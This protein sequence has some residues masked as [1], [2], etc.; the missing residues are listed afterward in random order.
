MPSGSGPNGARLAP[1]PDRPSP[2]EARN[3]AIAAFTTSRDSFEDLDP[4]KG[5]GPAQSKSLGGTDSG[6]SS[7]LLS[8]GGD[9]KVTRPFLQNPW[10]YA[11]VTAN[12][13]ALAS[14]PVV[15]T[16]GK[17]KTPIDNEDHPLVALFDAPNPL[18]SQAKF[19]KQ[20]VN[21]H[22]LWG[23]TYLILMKEDK[24]PA[25]DGKPARTEYRPVRALEGEGM[26]AKVETPD[27]VWPVAGHLVQEVVDKEHGPLPWKY[28]V[29]TGTGTVEYLAEA[30]VQLADANP[31]SLLRG[32]G[33]MTAVIRDAAKAY[34][35]DR[36][37][38]ALLA[39]GGVPGGV[40][41]V[42]GSLPDPELRAIRKAWRET[43]EKPD[44]HHK[45]AILPNG[46]K[47]TPHGFS[48]SEM[49]FTAFREW[50][51][52][53][54]MA[55]FG[56]TKPILG[57]TDDVN[58]SNAQEAY[59][60][61]WEVQIIPMVRFFE[62]EFNYKFIRRIK[63]FAGKKLR[64][65]LSLDD[66]EALR[67]DLDAKVDRTLKLYKDGHRTFNEAAGLAGWDLGE[68]PVTGG[69][70]RWI[71]SQLLPVELALEGPPEPPPA[72]DPGDDPEEDD[73]QED[74]DTT[75]DEPDED[76][77]KSI[78]AATEARDGLL[79]QYWRAHDEYLRGHE[80][81]FQKAVFGEFR[82][83]LRHTS[84]RLD[85]LARGAGARAGVG[86]TQKYV[87]TETEL[88]RLLALNLE[89]WTESMYS[90]T[91]PLMVDVIES[92]AQRLSFEVGG[93][94]SL[95]AGTDPMVLDF[96]RHKKLR[97]AEGWTSTLAADLQRKMVAVLA[98]AP[99]N[100][101]SLAHAIADVLDE[102][103][104]EIEIMHGQAG[105]RAMMIART[106]TT[107]ASSFAR[108]AQM[109]AEG[110]KE[111]TWLSSRDAQVRSTHNE[112]NGLTRAVGQ[113]FGYSLR[114]PGDPQGAAANV[115]HC[116]CTTIPELPERAIPP[117]WNYTPS[118][119]TS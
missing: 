116:R 37:D 113:S 115:I 43:H 9:R 7:W 98:Q 44:S 57:I 39:N 69:D 108:A 4:F 1:L 49:D 27:E 68:Q 71:P 5:S 88:E 46:T 10:V 99:A 41:S 82:S 61:F 29:S 97:I 114:F 18:Q 25:A 13:R 48:P 33:P 70:E 65:T 104:G 6:V 26:M 52:Q 89:A 22:L 14:L 42:E 16:E 107:S 94:V 86:T 23:E 109:V 91:A 59:R 75:E 92:A 93:S 64:F 30:V 31:H 66:A 73:E 77:D 2:K 47:Y 60:V 79:G 53:T 50:I 84:T 36:Y 112:L 51:R 20:L 11:S 12:A 106:E 102:L 81:H 15:I 83:F 101:P 17:E 111:H 21:Y 58:R 80:A 96:L 100:L 110:V 103:K 63:E 34:Q 32:V 19:F 72:P 117:I 40:L 105:K 95:L 85:E 55:A 45:T 62:D 118:D 24:I 35:I 119:V 3:G 67:E 78:T 74:S 28:K 54:I 38:D 90:T 56:V 76:E 87:V 8:L